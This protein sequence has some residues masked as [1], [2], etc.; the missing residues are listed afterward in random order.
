[1]SSLAVSLWTWVEMLRAVSNSIFP[2]RRTSVPI[3][4]WLQ[5][6]DDKASYTL[7][8]DMGF[9]AKVKQIIFATADDKNLYD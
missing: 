2:G 9:F 5:V 3:P 7:L 8:P 4:K 1:M 6:M